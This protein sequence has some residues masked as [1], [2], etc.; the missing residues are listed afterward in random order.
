MLG[1]NLVE[2]RTVLEVRKQCSNWNGGLMRS[3]RNKSP[4]DSLNVR[5]S[6]GHEGG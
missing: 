2:I 3:S 4:F 6:C 1:K 5:S